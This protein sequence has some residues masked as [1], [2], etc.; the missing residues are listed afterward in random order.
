MNR[1]K[2]TNKREITK[3]THPT[4]APLPPNIKEIF[5]NPQT[6]SELDLQHQKDMPDVTLGTYCMRNGASLIKAGLI[7]ATPYVRSVGRPRLN[8]EEDGDLVMLGTKVPA[9]IHKALRVKAAETGTS[10]GY[11]VTMALRAYLN[12]TP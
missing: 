3:T 7:S 8:K 4:M 9:S 1:E 11:E 10:I 12:K 2:N 6:R 5:Y